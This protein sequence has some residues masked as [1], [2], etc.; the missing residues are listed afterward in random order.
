MKSRIAFVLPNLLAI[1]L[2]ASSSFVAAQVNALPQARH[3]LVYGEAHARAIPDRFRITLE[4]E[5]V[6][7]NADTARRKVETNLKGVLDKLKALEV[8]DREIVA[9]SLNIAS[10]HRYNE[11]ADEEIFVGTIVSRDL[12]VRFDAKEK[13]ERFLAG[14]TTSESLQI[15]NVTTELSSEAALRASLRGKAIESTREKAQIMASAYGAKL[16]GLYSVSD[17][18]PQ[19]SYGIREGNWPSTYQW[20]PGD[21]NEAGTL[22]SVVVTGTRIASAP[23]MEPHAESFQTGYVNFTDKI[24]AVFLIED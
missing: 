11:K 12:K 17:V 23:A 24:Y 3:I 8:P 7:K 2:L 4:F 5:S 13:L 21:G 19:F 16:A 22:D 9:T 20:I 18:A 10:K 1:V 6:D 15:S 14:I